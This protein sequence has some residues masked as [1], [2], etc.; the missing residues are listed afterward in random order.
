MKEIEFRGYDL[1]TKRW[2]YGSCV[3]LERYSGY[4]WS[5]NPEEAEKKHQAEAFDDYIFFTEMNDWGLETRKLKATVDPKSV[6]QWIGLHDKHGK[7]I[8][9]G[10]IISGM[11]YDKNFPNNTF[12]MFDQRYAVFKGQNG[13]E[14][15]S[16]GYDCEVIGNTYENPEMLK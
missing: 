14:L 2:Y 8:Y 4:A 16:L 11:M 15:I 1:D 5:D 6:G 3:R 10:D 13:T 12:V 9:V 7:R